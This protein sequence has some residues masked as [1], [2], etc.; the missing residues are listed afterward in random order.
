MG[1]RV[2]SDYK[3]G[4]VWGLSYSLGAISPR[5]CSRCTASM[6][7]PEITASRQGTWKAEHLLALKQAMERYDFFAQLLQV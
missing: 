1:L 6:K 5:T 7:R 2:S 3:E 4:E